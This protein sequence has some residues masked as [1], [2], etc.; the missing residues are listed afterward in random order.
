MI[1]NA[2]TTGRIYRYL[3]IAPILLLLA[4]CAGMPSHSNRGGATVTKAAFGR[5]ED[6]RQVT[7]Y[8]VTNANG[9]KAELLDYG[10]IMHSLWLPNRDGKLEDVLLSC[11]TPESYAKVS[12]YFGS[13]AGRYANRI[14]KGKFT[15][16]GKTYTLATNNNENHLH[17]GKIGFDKVIWNARAFVEGPNAGVEF[18]YHSKDGEEGYPGNLR[19]SV[20]YTLTQ[21]NGFTIHYGA[22]TDKATPIN[23]T[24]HNYYNLAGQGN[25]DILSHIVQINADRYTPVDAGGI[26]TGELPPVAGTP[27]DFTKPM[28]IGARIAQVEGGYDHNYVLNG[29]MGVLRLAA[30]VHAPSSGRTMEIL[31]TEPGVQFYTG[32]FLDGTITGKDGKVYKKNYGLCLET[33]HFPDSPNRPNFPSAILHPGETYSHFTV[34]NF[35][36]E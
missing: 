7:A 17:G 16:E 13:V 30:R 2:N 34:F 10:A 12:P 32:N 21:S 15:L 26:P 1:G 28:P 33:Q 36:V 23:L 11:A 18:T 27:M 3:R 31:T 29:K 19:C 6:G 8:T 14:A 4:G 22:T 24:Q 5:L 35:Y 9:V 25:G 20:V